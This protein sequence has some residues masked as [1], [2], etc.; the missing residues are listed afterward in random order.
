MTSNGTVEAMWVGPPD[1]T[2]PNKQ[3]L[4]PNETVVTISAGEAEAS[5]NWRVVS[6]GTPKVKGKGE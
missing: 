5:D 1:Y 4:V 2:L 6:G 3:L